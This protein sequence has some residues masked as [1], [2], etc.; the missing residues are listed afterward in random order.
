MAHDLPMRQS[1]YCIALL[2]AAGCGSSDVAPR[3]SP[4]S[5]TPPHTSDTVAVSFD[6]RFKGVGVLTSPPGGIGSD[7]FGALGQWFTNQSGTPLQI[8]TGLCGAQLYIG[9]AWFFITYPLPATDTGLTTYYQGGYWQNLTSVFDTTRATDTVIMSLDLEPQDSTFAVAEYV[10]SAESGYL[11]GLHSVPLSGLA[12]AAT[13]EGLAHHVITALSFLNGQV[14][15][16]AYAW[17]HNTTDVYD[18]QVQTA[19]LTAI[20]AAAQGMA[21]NG[22]TITALGGD[23]VDGFVVVGTRVHGVTTPRNFQ[24]LPKRQAVPAGYAVV[25]YLFNESAPGEGTTMLVEQ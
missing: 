25:G 24:I 19:S 15:Y 14:Q 2:I 11:L 12:A 10:A 16:L 20:P 17:Q 9:C 7:V 5:P 6:L 1:Y 4:T 13:Q 22:Y 21:A 3:S 8:G 23:S 18:A